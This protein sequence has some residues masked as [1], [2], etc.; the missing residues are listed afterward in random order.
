MS[1]VYTKSLASDFS[2]NLDTSQFHLEI[3]DDVTIT[4]NL[5][6]ITT[7]GDD[8]RIKFDSA[9][10]GAELTQLDVLIAAHTPDTEP[11]FHTTHSV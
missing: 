11:K 6:G 7:F 10:S 3:Q 8:V 9:L 5:T 1:T 4:T 2:G